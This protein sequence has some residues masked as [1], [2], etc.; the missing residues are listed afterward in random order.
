MRLHNFFS[1]IRGAT[2]LQCFLKKGMDDALSFFEATITQV[3]IHARGFDF[4]ARTEKI[5]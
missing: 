4:L 1:Q 3:D 2:P 5:D